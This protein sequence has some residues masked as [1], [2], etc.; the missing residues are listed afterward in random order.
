M[1]P[2]GFQ[3][4]ELNMKIRIFRCGWCRGEPY[5]SDR[6]SMRKHMREEH[7]ILKNLANEPHAPSELLVK[8]RTW[9]V[10]EDG[11]ALDWGTSERKK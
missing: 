9:I 8:K 5:T 6:K 11:V 2:S 7:R 10:E 3:E 1:G 4:C